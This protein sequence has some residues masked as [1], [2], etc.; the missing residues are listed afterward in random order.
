MT[1]ARTWIEIVIINMLHK[2]DSLRTKHRGLEIR[3]GQGLG[4]EMGLQ[5]EQ[6]LVLQLGQGQGLE[7]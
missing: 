1:R 2:Y 4:L 6:R 3:L 7:L 5:L